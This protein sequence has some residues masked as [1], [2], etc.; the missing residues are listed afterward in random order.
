MD[1]ALAPGLV[2]RL[3]IDASGLADAELAKQ[4]DSPV[5]ADAHGRVVLLV[6]VDVAARGV[7]RHRLSREKVRPHEHLAHAAGPVVPR[8]Q[9]VVGG[10]CHRELPGLADG[11]RA[12]AVALGHLERSG[13]GLHRAVAARAVAPGCEYPCSELVQRCSIICAATLALDMLMVS[14]SFVPAEALATAQ[15]PR[16]SSLVP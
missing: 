12:V 3:A 16:Q 9:P 11:R 7:D 4:V 6:E 15:R 13:V 8:D 1:P 5:V 2:A 14:S 10:A